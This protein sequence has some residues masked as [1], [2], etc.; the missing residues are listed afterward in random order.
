[1]KFHLHALVGILT[2]PSIACASPEMS[3]VFELV[4]QRTSEKIA[5]AEVVIDLRI[6][7]AVPSAWSFAIP[8]CRS[9]VTDSLRICSLVASR[10][11]AKSAAH[12]D[13]FN[14]AEINKN[15]RFKLEARKSL[16]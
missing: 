8:F 1:M 6:I 7:N 2:V 12:W 13:A 11:M 5:P 10:W 4:W 9:S 15:V 16:Q 3:Q 14:Y